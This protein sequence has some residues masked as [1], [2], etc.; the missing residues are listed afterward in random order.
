MS[1]NRQSQP[2]SSRHPLL[3]SFLPPATWRGLKCAGLEP[4]SAASRLA[5]LGKGTQLLRSTTFLIWKRG[6]TIVPVPFTGLRE[7]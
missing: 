4:G 6:A 2:P 3:L 7:E 1:L 5:D